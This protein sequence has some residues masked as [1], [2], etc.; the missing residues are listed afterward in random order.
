MAVQKC[1]GAPP[2][3]PS[4][5]KD[6]SV[7]RL[8]QAGKPAFSKIERAKAGKRIHALILGLKLW[9]QELEEANSAMQ[10]YKF[11]L[12]ALDLMGPL[13]QKS[14]FTCVHPAALQEC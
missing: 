3:V 2:L 13:P 9:W 6:N 7:D 14:M 8:V 4:A 10:V 5:C 1:L 11:S 12:P